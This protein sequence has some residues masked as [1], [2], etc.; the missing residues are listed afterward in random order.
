MKHA[1]T[2]ALDRLAPLL[3]QLRL[4][5]GLKEKS[6]GCF[7][8]RG[9]SF[10]HFHEHGVDELYADIGLGSA[11]ER[12]PAM[13]AAQHKTILKRTASVLADGKTAAKR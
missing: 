10:L 6:R 3:E 11:F 4:Q 1:G 2:K 13:T 8:I 9:R 12:L 5:D 7:Y